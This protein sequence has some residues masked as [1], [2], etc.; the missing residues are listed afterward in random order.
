MYLLHFNSLQWFNVI[1]SNQTTKPKFMQHS[2]KYILNNAQNFFYIS[3]TLWFLTQML[4]IHC[5]ICASA[6]LLDWTAMALS[7]TSSAACRGNESS[8][9][10]LYPWAG[11]STST[12]NIVRDRVRGFEKSLW[13]SILH[14]ASRV[15][16]YFADAVLC[17]I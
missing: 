11:L 15:C 5:W 16:F 14:S 13:F 1:Y 4:P 3:T 2:I 17:L 9:S 10:F 8:T 12:I 7:N 6:L